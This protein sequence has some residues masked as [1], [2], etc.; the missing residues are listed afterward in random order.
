MAKILWEA[1]GARH[2]FTIDRETIEIG[3]DTNCDVSLNHDREVSRFHA[4]IEKRTSELYAI[5]DNG[6]TNGTTVN[7]RKIGSEFVTLHHN[8]VIR[9]GKTPMIFVDENS[10]VTREAL[11]EIAEEMEKGKGFSTI[12]HEI[13]ESGR[14]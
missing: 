4:T 3:R 10:D 13:V 7:G 5:Q 9:M 12:F 11:D 1:N 6:S 8:D 14:R 2:S